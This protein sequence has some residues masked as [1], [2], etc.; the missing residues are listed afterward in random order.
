[1]EVEISSTVPC[2]IENSLIRIIFRSD[3]ANECIILIDGHTNIWSIGTHRINGGK[4]IDLY[5]LDNCTISGNTIEGFERPIVANSC[6]E[7]F[8]S[9]TDIVTE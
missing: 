8:I 4:A 2:D 5:L 6:D 7:Q 9:D 1:M 3:C